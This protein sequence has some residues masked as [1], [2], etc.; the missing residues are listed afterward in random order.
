MSEKP[1]TVSGV[2][3]FLFGAPASERE[4]V[5]HF[6]SVL[7]FEPV[8]EGRIEAAEAKS[9]YGH[10][11]G[12]TSFRLAHPGCKT[13]D[14]GH[15]R[16]QLWDDLPSEGLG[17]AA[18][19]DTGSRWMGIYTRAALRTMEAFHGE[20]EK[21]GADW[22]LTGLVRAAFAWPEPEITLDAPFLGL[23]E[24]IALA[25]DFRVA[26]CERVG[27]DRPGFGTFVAE[28]PFHNTEGTHANIV[29][30]MNSFS[31]AFYKRVFGLQTMA[32]G[33]AHDSG[34]EA[35]TIEAL[36]LKPGQ[37]FHIERLVHPESPAGMLQVYSCYSGSEDRRADARPGARGIG[38]YA[39]R[40]RDIVAF[41]A[42]IAEE[43]A[44]GIGQ[45]A[46]NEFGE[47]QLAFDAPDGIAWLVTAA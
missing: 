46:D 20:K 28:L 43:G 21:R 36:K 14:T 29:Q 1:H 33:E 39:Y 15:V 37:T 6:W 18:A 47:L 26:F 22:S 19:L 41:R 38:C 32:N 24:F 13:Y 27:F 25:P 3:E 34:E 11:S 45:V 31:T 8:A 42:L 16:L 4:D 2:H 44:T 30:P 17:D 23:R 7:G 40:V 12:L 5:L 10:A 9:L 35:P